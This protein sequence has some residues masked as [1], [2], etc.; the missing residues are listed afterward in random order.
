MS[1]H[2]LP[3]DLERIVFTSRGAFSKRSWPYLM[4]IVLPW[5]LCAGQRCMTRLFAL[6]GHRRSL[7]GYYR[8]LSEGKIRLDILFRL[9][10]DLILRTFPTPALTLV[11]DDTLVP[12]WGS[13]LA[14][15]RLERDPFHGE[16]NYTIRPHPRRS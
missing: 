1:R 9:L 6:S 14:R 12:K 4:A 13:Q 10:F 15:V 5:V 3:S 8:F 7:S 2:S 11:V 16:W